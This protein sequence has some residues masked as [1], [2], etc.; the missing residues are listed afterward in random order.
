MTGMEAIAAMTRIMSET[1]R[2]LMTVLTR[3]NQAIG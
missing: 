3:I 2:H 1:G